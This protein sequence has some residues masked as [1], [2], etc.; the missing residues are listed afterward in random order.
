MPSAS[1]EHLSA[2]NPDKLLG[3][4]RTC[5]WHYEYLVQEATSNPTD[6]TVL[7]RLDDALDEYLALM[8][9]VSFEIIIIIA[10]NTE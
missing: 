8:I 7:A 1:K 2:L 6:S 5:Y 9:R 3:T 10:N 4:F